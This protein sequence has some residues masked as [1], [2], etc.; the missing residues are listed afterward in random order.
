MSKQ[1]KNDFCTQHVLNLYFGGNSMNNLLP[2]FGLTDARMRT[3][4]KDLPVPIQV[5]KYNFR[6]D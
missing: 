3:S 4:E 5:I 1:T 2:Y 6:G